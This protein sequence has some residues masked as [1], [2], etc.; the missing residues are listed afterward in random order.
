MIYVLFSFWL[1]KMRIN[2]GNIEPSVVGI[3]I[4]LIYFDFWTHCCFAFEATEAKVDETTKCERRK[5]TISSFLSYEL[6]VDCLNRK[7]FL[8][9][10]K[11]PQYPDDAQLVI[12]RNRLISTNSKRL[13]RLPT[14]GWRLGS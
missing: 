7:R 1:D 14:S 2:S 10:S 6:L 12:L 13:P 9:K 3:E 8:R 4:N 11:F 5:S